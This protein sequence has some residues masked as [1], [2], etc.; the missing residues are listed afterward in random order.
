METQ[1]PELIHTSD[2]QAATRTRKVLTFPPRAIVPILDVS[3]ER[4]F[5]RWTRRAHP[6]K[7]IARTEEL[8]RE[9]VECVLH[10]CVVEL[11]RRAA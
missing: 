2:P 7:Y 6:I 8:R 1:T 9:E 5:H 11:I 10:E 3:K 4:I